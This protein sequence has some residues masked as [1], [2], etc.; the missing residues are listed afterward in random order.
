[1]NSTLEIYG[2]LARAFDA[3]NRDLF[4]GTLSAAII[5]VTDQ[6]RFAAYYQPAYFNV[7]GRLIDNIVLNPDHFADPF[8]VLSY[9]VHEQNHAYQ[10]H[11][12]RDKL[13]VDVVH[14]QGFITKMEEIGIMPAE[15]TG[16]DHDAIIAFGPFY[17]TATKLISSGFKLPSVATAGR[18]ARP[19]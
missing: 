14:N 17:Q 4:N 6:T 10:Y 5:T 8:K 11:F 19:A 9:L 3:F 2:Q 1:M 13:M 15:R 12:Q 16:A 18:V 7:N